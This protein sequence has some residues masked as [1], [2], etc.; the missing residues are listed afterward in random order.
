MPIA[1][2]SF[3]VFKPSSEDPSPQQTF[4]QE[5]T[6]SD[7]AYRALTRENI[8]EL[9]AAAAIAQA[10]DDEMAQRS[11]SPVASDLSNTLSIP[12]L[13]KSNFSRWK[14]SVEAYARRLSH[15]RL[16]K[17]RGP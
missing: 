1:F 13:T 2:S 17:T 6:L 8:A 14:F 7:R 4:S 11:T 16:F 10:E 12:E 5:S 15:R 9:G 3:G